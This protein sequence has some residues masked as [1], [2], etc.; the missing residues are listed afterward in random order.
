MDEKNPENELR[1]I[2]KM[3]NKTP[4]PIQ[5]KFVKCQKRNGKINFP[6]ISFTSPIDA[7]TPLIKNGTKSG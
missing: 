4:N 2:L 3:Y 6:I 7:Y 5:C 1:V